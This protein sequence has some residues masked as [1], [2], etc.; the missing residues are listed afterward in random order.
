MAFGEG[1]V[2][3]VFGRSSLCSPSLCGLFG[4]L[5][6]DHKGSENTE[7]SHPPQQA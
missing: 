3:R 6:L 7:K 2:V 4:E 1:H 5:G